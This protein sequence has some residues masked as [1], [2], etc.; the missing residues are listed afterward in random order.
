VQLFGPF[1][2]KLESSIRTGLGEPSRR[3]ASFLFSFPNEVHRREKILDLFW[4]DSSD[5]R[6][7]HSL[8]TALYGLRKLLSDPANPGISIRSN[9]HD[10]HLDV[11]NTN[12]VDVHR[13]RT[14]T[15]SAFGVK[16]GAID[17]DALDQAVN[18]YGGIFLEEYVEDWVLTQREDL[19]T[20][21]LRSLTHLMNW[22]Q[23]EKRYDVAISC[24]R[25]ILS[26]DPTR[27]RIHRAMMLL[28]FLLG[29]RGEALRQFKRCETAL[30]D[31]CDVPPMPETRSLLA[32]I[33]SGENAQ[34]V[35]E[36]LER[37]LACSMQHYSPFPGRLRSG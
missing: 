20:L 1:A 17:F 36:L 23:R 3:L 4:P 27:E 28:Y 2:V 10:V 25:R 18:L 34:H 30:R 15:M 26:S 24:G 7:R 12:I 19:Q 21:Y 8:N 31:E 22:N 14:A 33:R 37:E 29:E 13:F 35:P 9:L 16:D 11:A 6:A 5:S 32:L